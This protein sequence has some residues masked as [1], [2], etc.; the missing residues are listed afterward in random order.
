MFKIDSNLEQAIR[1]AKKNGLSIIATTS[2]SNSPSHAVLHML[3]GYKK[4][5]ICIEL[6][7]YKAGW[8]LSEK[9][10]EVLKT[11]GFTPRKTGVKKEDVP[12]GDEKKWMEILAALLTIPGTFLT[13]SFYK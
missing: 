9:A 5:F 1:E 13:P 12:I 11:M 6:D 8:D 4:G 3:K 7:F 10:S 2:P